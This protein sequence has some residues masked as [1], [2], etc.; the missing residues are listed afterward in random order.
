MKFVSTKDSSISYSFK[1]AVQLNLPPEGGLFVP[2]SFEKAYLPE[3]LREKDFSIQEMA[4]YCLWP[5]LEEDFTQQA[6]N[7]IIDQT[8]SFYMPVRHFEEKGIHVLELF[9][10]PTAAF[11]DIGATFMAGCLA[12]WQGNGEETTILV[13]TSGDTGGAVANAFYQKPGFRV[14]IL[15]PDGKISPV[16]E[17]QIAG[18]GGNVVALAVDGTFDDCQRM[19]KAVFAN[20]TISKKINLTSANSINL[21]RWLPQ[22]VFYGLAWSYKERFKVDPVLCVPSGNYGNISAAWL[23]GLLG[24]DFTHIIAAHN[25]NDTIPRYLKDDVYAPKQTIETLANAMD[26]S[27]P[28]NFVRLQYLMNNFPEY[29]QPLFSAYTVS[30]KEI[31][32]TIHEVW[33][34][35]QYLLDPHT[36]TSWA[37][38]KK[39]FGQGMCMSTAHPGK[40]EHVITKALGFFPEDWKPEISGGSLQRIRIKA[41]IT[42]LEQFLLN[43]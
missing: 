34:E 33:H 40:F 17:M 35:F 43:T 27:D 8:F 21:A 30:D 28:G 32:S 42:N 12:A 41:N 25:A 37:V 31:L 38:I 2:A 11:K 23:A 9:H 13:A 6:L 16:Q 15:Y 7:E 39:H 19:V 36:A 29:K 18:Q 14:V 3:V 10:G 26:V 20:D 22:T 5:F 1:Q 24:C 4:S